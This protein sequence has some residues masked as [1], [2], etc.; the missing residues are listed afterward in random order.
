[1]F[2]ACYSS[3]KCKKKTRENP[4]PQPL[5]PPPP[6]YPNQTKMSDGSAVT[7]WAL[8]EERVRIN[9]QNKARES[10]VKKDTYAKRFDYDFHGTTEKKKKT[11]YNPSS[12]CGV[13]TKVGEAR[14][15]RRSQS[16]RTRQSRSAAKQRRGS[17]LCRYAARQRQSKRTRRSQSKR[18]RQRQSLTRQRRGSRRH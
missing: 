8:N 17:R 12:R 5:S 15:T 9:N 11:P 10:A 13:E 16:K 1:M 14:G 2:S 4:P 3:G 18:T 7:N 6:P